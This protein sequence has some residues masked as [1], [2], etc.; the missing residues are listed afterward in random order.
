M[1]ALAFELPLALEATAP[2]EARGIARHAVRLLVANGHTGAITHR[3][4]DELPEILQ[5]GDLMVV[6]VSATLPAAVLGHR[7]DGAP[8]GGLDARGLRRGSFVTPDRMPRR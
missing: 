6:N 1:R 2:P 5:A 4:F 7:R 3:R 8:A